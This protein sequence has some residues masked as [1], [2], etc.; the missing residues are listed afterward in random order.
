MYTSTHW[1]KTTNPIRLSVYMQLLPQTVVWKSSSAYHIEMDGRG[2]RVPQVN[3]EGKQ[4][5]KDRRSCRLW[6]FWC[7]PEGFRCLGSRLVILCVTSPHLQWH[8]WYLSFQPMRARLASQLGVLCWS[9]NFGPKQSSRGTEAPQE[10]R[11]R[12]STEVWIFLLDRSG[13]WWRHSTREMMQQFPD[14]VCAWFQ[15]FFVAQE[16]RRFYRAKFNLTGNPGVVGKVWTTFWFKCLILK[17]KN[18]KWHVLC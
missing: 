6:P 2:R 7:H 14:Q 12:N 15:C 4:R 13:F 17:A 8:C 5:M 3:T 10:V 1:Q 11:L 18:H 9:L 16:T